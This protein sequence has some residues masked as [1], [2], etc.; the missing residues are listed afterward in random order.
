V[1]GAVRSV[2]PATGELVFEAPSASAAE[3]SEALARAAERQRGW[4]AR[5]AEERGAVLAAFA[6]RLE[7]DADRMASLIVSE[8]GKCRG[9]AVA[10]VEWTVRSARWYAQRPP[11]EECAGSSRVLRRPLGT[12]AAITPWNVPLV[13]P[14]WKF[15]PALMAGNAVVWKPSELASASAV[16]LL[17]L[18]EASGD[19]GALQVVLGGPDVARQL[20]NDDRVAG[21][22]FTGS[23]AAG[24]EVASLCARRFA[25]CALE[26]GGVCP[27]IVFADANLDHAAD[28]IVAAATA[29]N[30]QKCT[31]TRH[32]L[33]DHD[34]AD[35][36][37]DRLEAR[38]RALRVGD[39]ANPGTAIGP[40][41]HDAARRE[42]DEV[43]R[44]R[45]YPRGPA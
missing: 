29:I 20:C 17:R 8:V 14:A 39:P 25:R 36:L 38:I 3:V 42:A 7:R 34:V 12:V 19:S 30:G 2:S 9:E 31:A 45:W 23:S 43:L 28:C 27:A 21:V 4:A 15:L 32:V 26:L 6:D 44:S 1:R 35:T 13:T 10:E 22:H 5:P 41:I 37:A 11:P 24:Q 40:L 16:A 18:M 33:A